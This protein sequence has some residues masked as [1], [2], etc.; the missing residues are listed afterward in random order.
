VRDYSAGV[1]DPAQIEKRFSQL[2]RTAR[3][4]MPGAK[5]E[6]MA[7]ARYVGQSYELTIPRD[8]SF[9]EEHQRIYGYSDPARPVEIVTV[10]VRASIPVAKPQPGKLKR[11]ARGPASELRKVFTGSKFRMLPVFAREQVRERGE[12]GPALVVDYG[13][14][15]LIPP[16]WKFAVDRAGN[17]V[18][19]L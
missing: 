14:T 9:H 10:R 5:L 18:A 19:R 6:R 15:T 1:L 2:E 11:A 3:R 17:L 12:K 7:D 16:G 8:G 13:A 4:D